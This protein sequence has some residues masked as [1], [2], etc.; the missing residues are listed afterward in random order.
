MVLLCEDSSLTV[1]RKYGS[2]TLCNHPLFSCRGFI[3]C[4]RADSSTLY[5]GR[6]AAIVIMWILP[7]LLIELGLMTVLNF[8]VYIYFGIRIKL[9][10][11]LFV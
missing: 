4:L 10:R 2:S 9:L 8:S 1:L 5:Y 7:M 3:H 11:R 6:L